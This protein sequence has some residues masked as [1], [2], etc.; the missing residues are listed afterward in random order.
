MVRALSLLIVA[1]ALF[2]IIAPFALPFQL[3]RKAKR[4]E[5]IS[6]YL[7]TIAI[8]I[9]QLGGAILYEKE[10]W[11]VSSYTYYLCS[12]SRTFACRFNKIIDF[13]FGEWHCRDSYYRER[14]E[15]SNEFKET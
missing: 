12:E 3:M 4:R 8:G 5:S 2:I 7:F 14:R 6:D 13:L 10:N 9:D 15:D 11:T 1:I